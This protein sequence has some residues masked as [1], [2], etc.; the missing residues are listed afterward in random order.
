M[1]VEN[2]CNESVLGHDWEP[3][4]SLRATGTQ[5]VEASRTEKKINEVGELHR[6][7]AE[8]AALLLLFFSRH[9]QDRPCAPV[10][11]RW[12]LLALTLEDASKCLSNHIVVVVS[13]VIWRQHCP[14]MC[15]CSKSGLTMRRCSLRLSPVQHSSLPARAGLGEAS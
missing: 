15:F 14:H 5:A 11:S 12:D 8:R 13:G 6:P 4:N 10:S 7:S 2:M 1:I 9:L 3:H